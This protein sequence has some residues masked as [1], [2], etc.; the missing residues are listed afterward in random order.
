[1][2][3]EWYCFIVQAL[4]IFLSK[5]FEEDLGLPW[6]YITENHFEKSIGFVDKDRT[7]NNQNTKPPVLSQ[8]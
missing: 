4:R 3:F 1:M 5:V 2:L 6:A 7:R 8:N